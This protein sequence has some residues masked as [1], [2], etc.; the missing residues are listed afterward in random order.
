MT[1]EVSPYILSA[2]NLI[3]GIKDTD[4]WVQTIYEDLGSQIDILNNKDDLIEYNIDDI[5]F[6]V[7]FN[8][9]RTD[10]DDKWNEHKMPFAVASLNFTTLEISTFHDFN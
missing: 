9:Y 8:A 10:K 7:I 4:V 2:L 5:G 6:S 3:F 1:T